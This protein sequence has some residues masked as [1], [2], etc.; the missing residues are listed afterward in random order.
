MVTTSIIPRARLKHRFSCGTKLS[1]CCVTQSLLLF[2]LSVF[3]SRND[4]VVCFNKLLR[5]ITKI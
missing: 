3:N 5:A 4:A 1:K 2:K